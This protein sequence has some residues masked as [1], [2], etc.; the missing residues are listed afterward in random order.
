MKLAPALGSLL[1]AMASSVA[2]AQT[3]PQDVNQT[4][5]KV[6]KPKVHHAGGKHD[7][8]AHEASEKAKA[9]GQPMQD[10]GMHAGGKHDMQ[11]HKAAIKAD[12]ANKPAEEPPK[13]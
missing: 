7:Q 4:P 5:Q 11:G 1:F 8:M 2:L 3:S 12:Q 6:E 9:H 10:M 13:K